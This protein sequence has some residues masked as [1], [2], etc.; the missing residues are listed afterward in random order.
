MS[1]SSKDFDTAW[2]K[3]SSVFIDRQQYQ[4][5]CSQCQWHQAKFVK[6]DLLLFQIL[7]SIPSHCYSAPAYE[8]KVSH[9]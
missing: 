1:R 8:G 2:P 9:V 4:N 6:E 7:T 5:V 3:G